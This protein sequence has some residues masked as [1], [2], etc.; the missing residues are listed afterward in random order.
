MSDKYKQVLTVLQS[1]KAEINAILT[2]PDDELHRI[3]LTNNLQKD[4]DNLALLTKSG[5]LVGEPVQGLKPAKK[6]G[7]KLIGMHKKA[8]V[9]L[10]PSEE[11]VNVLKAKVETAFE[12]F[13]NTP[14][15]EILKTY[16][17]LVIRGVAKK[18][19]MKVTADDP[20]KI[21]IPFINDIKKE[22]KVFTEKQTAAAKGKAEAEQ[23]KTKQADGS[24]SGTDAEKVANNA[25]TDSAA[26]ASDKKSDAND[27]L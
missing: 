19:Q 4:H 20:A 24:A 22:I 12:A 13:P 2:D 27:L 25:G 14:A 11:K 18:V 1:A 17:D 6:I 15:K 16:D 10:K 21:T 26:D 23:G 5:D 7:G 3:R 8:K 9:D